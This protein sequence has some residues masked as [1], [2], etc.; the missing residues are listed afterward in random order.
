MKTV[1]QWHKI[2]RQQALWT[3]EV[4]SYLFNQANII[5]ESQII[6][7]GCGTGALLNDIN[8][9]L[10]FGIDIDY[11]RLYFAKNNLNLSLL[12]CANA[13][14]LPFSENSF[15]HAYCHYLLLWVFSPK[16]VLEEM[17]RIII[18]GGKIIVIAEPDYS[19][20]KDH[21]EELKEIGKMQ[22]QRLV[23]QGANPFIGRDL[24]TLLSSVE[25]K[26][27]E[28]GV[29]KR[30]NNVKQSLDDWTLE[31]DVLQHDLENNIGQKE[32]NKLKNRDFITW[33]SGDRIFYIP[34]FYAIGTK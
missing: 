25:L 22:T 5:E 14:N 20:R 18:P 26:N 17:K 1:S 31:W 33:Q 7:I 13:I 34:T 19:K 9:S 24:N 16:A 3:K 29:I 30:D 12:S 6:E 32:F 10:S 15:D 28:T 27:I 21:P 23:D 4:R 2:F 8:L 11:E